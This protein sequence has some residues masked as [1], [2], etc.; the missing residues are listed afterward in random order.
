MK[1]GTAECGRGAA[2]GGRLRAITFDIRNEWSASGGRWTFRWSPRG[3]AKRSCVASAVEALAPY[4]S[5][6]D[7][8]AAARS[9]TFSCRLSCY[10]STSDD[11]TIKHFRHI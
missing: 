2:D 9:T 10:S 7:R 4:C 11:F 5:R 3:R 8:S 1:S 6:A